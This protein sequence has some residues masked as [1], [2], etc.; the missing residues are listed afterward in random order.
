MRSMVSMGA[1]LLLLGASTLGC[2]DDDDNS[3]TTPPPT[4]DRPDGGTTTTP[5]TE[6]VITIHNFRFDPEDLVVP[7]GATV[8]VRNMDSTPHSVTSQ[9][10]ED[11]YVKG[12]VAGI[13]F[14]TGV[15]G[16][17]TRTF[18]VPTTAASGTVVPYFCT[19]HTADMANDGEITIR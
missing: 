1:L 15:F 14:D 10:K 13:S 7:A 8:T 18:T 19:V 6:F 17:G 9:A 4:T 3:T 16:L 2:G 11:D 5:V 12:S